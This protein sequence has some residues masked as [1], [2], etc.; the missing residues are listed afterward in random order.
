[1]KSYDDSESGLPATWNGVTSRIIGCAIEVHRTLGP[2]LLERLYEDAMAYEL[3]RAGLEI[4]RQYVVRTRYKDVFLS[5]QRLD[6]VVAR[7][8]VVELKCIERVADVHLAQLVSYLRCANLP[9]GLLIN[10]N[11][12]RLTDGVYR[13]VNS[14]A[15]QDQLLSAS[16]ADSAFIPSDP[17]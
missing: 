14:R 1:M 5:E 9:V 11:V 3:G 6:L 12:P 8:V 7:G 17:C 10:F 4:N 13:R 16:S 15:Y 2:G